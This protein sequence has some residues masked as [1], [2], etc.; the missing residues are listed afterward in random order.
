MSKV[1]QNEPAPVRNDRASVQDLVIADLRERNDKTAQLVIADVEGRK[2]LGLRKYGTLLQAFNGRNALMD[3]YQEALD[4]LMY[5]RQALEEGELV[6][7]QYAYALGIARMLRQTV[8]FDT[9]MQV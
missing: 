8:V 2:Q 5:L 3:A 6:A 7:A 4:L 1:D 9:D